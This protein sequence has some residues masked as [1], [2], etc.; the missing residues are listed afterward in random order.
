MKILVTENQFQKILREDEVLLKVI[1]EQLQAANTAPANPTIPVQ[2]EPNPVPA[3][4]DQSQVILLQNEINEL[5]KGKQQE[6]LNMASIWIEGNDRQYIVHYGDQS[7]TLKPAQNTANAFNAI[8]DKNMKKTFGGI[9]MK[10]F[11]PQIEKNKRYQ[12]LAKKHPG[13]KEQIQKGPRVILQPLE[14]QRGYFVYTKTTKDPIA[15][16]DPE[17]KEMPENVY[18]FGTHYPLGEFFAKNKLYYKIGKTRRGRDRNGNR[19]RPHKI[20]GLLESGYLSLQLLPIQLNTGAEPISQGGPATG[21]SVTPLTLVDCFNFD[22]ITF[23]NPTQTDQQINAF[24][25]DLNTK[26]KQHGA[27][28]VKHIQSSNPTVMGYSSIDGDP[29]EKV[30]GKYPRCSGSGNRSKYD[31]CLSQERANVIADKLNKG[32]PDLGNAFKAVGGG[33][34]DKAQQIVQQ[35]YAQFGIKVNLN[36]KVGIKW[37]KGSNIMPTDTMDNRIFYVKPIPPYKTTQPAQP[38]QVQPAPQPTV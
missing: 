29:N 26:I 36:G 30:V 24:I 3:G 27:P 1:K 4:D 11:F 22:D 37:T 13:I 19:I 20:Y 35:D 9:D 6:I 18:P 38:Q 21:I 15:D 16:V 34:T 14:G 12:E 8:I 33:E 10:E 23:V 32:I 28:F 25:Q 17:G 2:T 5:L 7:E 31:L